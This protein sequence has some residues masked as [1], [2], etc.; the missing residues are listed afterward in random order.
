MKIY[1]TSNTT[2]TG[3]VS[4]TIKTWIGTL[5]TGCALIS[6][7]LSWTLHYTLIVIEISA[8]TIGAI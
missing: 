1:I 8:D 5:L 3:I 2:S 7:G 4:T 6:V